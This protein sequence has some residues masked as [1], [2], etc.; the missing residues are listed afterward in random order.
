MCSP[1]CVRSTCYSW[2]CSVARITTMSLLAAPPPPCP[3][4]NV[5]P[6]VYKAFEAEDLTFPGRD[7]IDSTLMKTL[8]GSMQ[9][10]P[11]T[12]EGYLGVGNGACG[13]GHCV[14]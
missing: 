11:L 1:L 7:S 3:R 4:I 2:L 13:G 8:D 6:D 9:C 12:K 10:K 14:T 5:A